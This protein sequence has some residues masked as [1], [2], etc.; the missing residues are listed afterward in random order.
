MRKFTFSLFIAFITISTGN[1]QIQKGTTV[2]GGSI[3]FSQRETEADP[4]WGASDTYRSFGV[5]PLFAKAIRE[6]LILGGEIVYGNDFHESG[7]IN[8]L[9]SNRRNYGLGIFIR[10]YR[11][12]GKSGF[13]LFLQSELIAAFTTYKSTVSSVNPPYS[14][15]QKSDGFTIGLNLYP[16]IAYAITPRMHIETGLSNLFHAGYFNSSSSNNPGTESKTE[17][18]GFNARIGLGGTT[19]WTVGV[20]FFLG[21]GT[22]ST[23]E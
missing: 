14:T 7:S 12:L 6:N 11:N 4:A 19:T 22:K 9:E 18:S 8:N 21:K 13:Y 20:K 23:K 2:L 10:G 3:E 1:A 5:S 15:V 16:G 17:T